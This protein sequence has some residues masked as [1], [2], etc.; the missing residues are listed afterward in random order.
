MTEIFRRLSAFAVF[1]AMQSGLAGLALAQGVPPASPG[2]QPPTYGGATQTVGS[3]PSPET[4][5]A[6]E[7]PV[8]YVTSVEVMGTSVEPKL[9]IVRVSG[10]TGSQGWSSP[11]LVPTFAGKPLDGILDLQFIATM[12]P[13]TQPAEGFVTISAIFPL[14]EGH[15]FKGVRVRASENA[16]ELKQ[17][18]GVNQ[19]H[20]TVNDCND[21]VGKKFCRGRSG[22]TGPAKYR[23]T[24]R[25]PQSLAMDRPVA[26]HQRNYPQSEPAQSDPQ[27]RQYDRRGLLG[28]T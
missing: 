2:A 21:C 25:S 24:G 13:Q 28:V 18:P 10:L 5:P 17:M 27:R 1:A 3:V 19:A 8:L 12:P 15:L 23:P 7:L 20:I 22:A 14:E 9:D 4:T 16:I 11:Q 26:R 6:T